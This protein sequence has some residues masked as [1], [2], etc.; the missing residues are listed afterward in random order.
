MRVITDLENQGE[1]NG[2]ARLDSATP[3]D[4]QPY[5]GVGSRSEIESNSATEVEN[6]APF[7]VTET[8]E[9]RERRYDALQ[10]L[11]LGKRQ[12]IL[13][14]IQDNV[15]QSLTEGQERNLDSLGDVGDQALM[16]RERDRS[17]FVME[18]RN[19]TRQ[20]LDEALIRL[21]EGTYGICAE[22]GIDINDKRLQAV[23]FAKLCVECQS[24]AE[25]LEQ[26]ERAEEREDR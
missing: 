5:R 3:N 20:F 23:P 11:L 2:V 19:R 24:R 26:I 4:N 8:A 13:R 22:C 16:N 9:E 21:R 25:L 15:G 1:Q 14:E 10:N 6:D 18:M 12:E 17:I 7:K